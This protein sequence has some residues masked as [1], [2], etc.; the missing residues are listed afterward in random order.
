MRIVRWMT[1]LLVAVLCVNGLPT[2]AASSGEA[3]YILTREGNTLS[4]TQQEGELT[5]WEAPDVTT[6]QTRMGG[7]ITL[8]NETDRTV[9][10]VLSS[11]SLPYGDTAALTYLDAVTIDIEQDGATCYHGTFTRLMDSDRKEIRL[12]NVAPGESRQ[13]SLSISCAYTYTGQVP[14]YSSL[15]WTFI[16]QVQAT[17]PTTTAED[18]FVERFTID[19]LLI[20]EIAGALTLTTGV[21]GLCLWL[22]RR[23]KQR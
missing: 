21:A 2:S 4:M 22:Y 8:R 17:T 7:V 5:F 19:W 16:P 10:F 23:R 18:P 1:A 12:V 9:D 11:V 15:V 3:V 6:G 14:S 20:A 13:L